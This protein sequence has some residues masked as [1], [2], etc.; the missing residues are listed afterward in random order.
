M[1]PQPSNIPANFLLK[2]NSNK[3]LCFIWTHLPQPASQRLLSHIPKNPAIPKH[4]ST[5]SQQQNEIADFSP[6]SG[7]RL[8]LCVLQSPLHPSCTSPPSQPKCGGIFGSA[9]LCSRTGPHAHSSP[10]CPTVLQ[11]ASTCN[12]KRETLKPQKAREEIQTLS[13][14]EIIYASKDSR[15]WCQRRTCWTQHI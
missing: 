11:V 15:R 6:A 3:A 5:L 12:R 13:A 14:S 10:T 7:S 1:P 2:W 4:T 9:Q 8:E